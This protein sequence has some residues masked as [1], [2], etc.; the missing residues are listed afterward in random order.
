MMT[1]TQAIAYGRR[2]GVRYY[3]KNQHDCIVGGCKTIKDAR[4]MVKRMK[5]HEHGK[6]L[7]GVLRIEPVGGKRV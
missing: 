6:D 5:N 2:V 3:I 4:A 7:Y 1:L